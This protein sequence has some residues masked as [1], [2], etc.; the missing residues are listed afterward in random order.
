L[1][2][3]KCCEWLSDGGQE[4]E[5]LPNDFLFAAQFVFP[6]S[7]YLPFAPPEFFDNKAIPRNVSSNFRAPVSLVA[8]GRTGVH[9]AAVPETA[10]NKNCEAL[11]AE[12]EIGV[13][14]KCLV[15][16]PTGDAV[17]PKDGYES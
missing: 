7:G 17:C 11:V 5:Q 6:N 13:A 12:D 2:R 3:L 4:L 16:A 1:A 15:A 8:A 14:R 9:W 10:V